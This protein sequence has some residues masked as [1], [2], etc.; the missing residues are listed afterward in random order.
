MSSIDMLKSKYEII[1]NNSEFEKYFK[2]T[3]WLFAEKIFQMVVGFFVI[4]LLT[5]YLGPEK[6]GLLAYSQSFIGIFVAFSTLGI[7]TILVREIT[8]NKDKNDVLIGTAITLKIIA[9]LVGMFIVFIINMFVEDEAAGMLINIIAFILIFQSLRTFDTYFQANVIS[10]YCVIANCIAFTCSSSIKLILI[11]VEADLVYFAYTLVF[12]SVVIALGYLYIYR[13]QKKSIISLKY[14]LK[15]AIYFLKNGW[16]LMLVAMAVFLYTKIDQIMIR[17]IVDSVAVGHYVAATRVVELFYFV[18]LIVTQSIFP[19]I[20]EMK[21][22]S[23]KEYFRFLENIYRILMWLVFPIAL[24]IFTYSDIIINILY[25]D[26]Y[27]SATSILNVLSFTV[28][29][30]AIGTMSTKILYVEHYEKKYLYRSVLGV[31]VNIALNFWL[32]DLFGAV[33]AA[34]STV[35]TLVIIYYV[36]DVFDKDLHKFFYLKIKCFIP[37]TLKK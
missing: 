36:Y 5:R 7:D 17:H 6:Y 26:E 21:L 20:V 28:V 32:I 1:K 9:S 25:G 35:I 16:P 31:C 13:L 33:G 18:P 12:D 29:L 4:I 23:E 14:N 22:K 37:S 27:A 19:K 3:S 15:I 24:V 2:N 11:Y 10:K 30:S 34:I 8:K